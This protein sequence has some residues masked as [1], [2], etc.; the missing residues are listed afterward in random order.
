MFTA[1]CAFVAGAASRDA[2]PPAGLPEIAFAGRSNV[3]KSSLINAL[4][5]RK[6]LARVSQ[7]PGATRQ[8]NFFALGEKLLLVDLPGYGFAQASKSLAAAWQSLVFSYLRGRTSLRR[9]ILLIDARRGVMPIDSQAMTILDEAA[10]SYLPVLTKIDKL[11]RPERELAI[12][13]CRER[14]ALHVAA[15]PDVLATSALTGEG[16]D[17]LRMHIAALT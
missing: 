4:L 16:L 5:S 15:Y 13:R 6:S 2:I 11:G 8:I 1:P 10:V 17:P 9:V 3:G 14:L 7:T 12:L